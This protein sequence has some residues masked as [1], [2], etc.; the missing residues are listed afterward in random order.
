MT[1]VR[2]HQGPTA[3]GA[4][5]ALGARAYAVGAEVAFADGAADL[6]TAAHEAA[7]VV[8]QRRGVARKGLDGGAS[9][10]FE[11][12]AD[13]VADAVVRGAPAAPILDRMA[14]AGGGAPTV[15]RD[16][17]PNPGAP[18]ADAAALHTS[19]GDPVV[20]VGGPASPSIYMSADWLRANGV[21]EGAVMVTG[22]THPAVVR[23]IIEKL[24]P[25]YPWA[26]NRPSAQLDDISA[27]FLQ[28][29][30]SGWT[31]GE[32]LARLD[33]TIFLSMGLPPERP[34]QVFS[35]PTG[36][37]LWIDTYYAFPGGAAPSPESGELERARLAGS[38][39]A[40]LEAAIGAPML[41]SERVQATALCEG[42]IRGGGGVEVVPWSSDQLVPFFGAEAVRAYVEARETPDGSATSVIEVP[43]G[44]FSLPSDATPDEAAL[45][46]RM[47]SEIYGSAE[48]REGRDTSATALLRQDIAALDELDRSPDRGELIAI[49]REMGQ[50]EG[51]MAQRIAIARAQLRRRQGAR[52][53]GESDPAMAG[54]AAP[55]PVARPVEG[56]ILNKSGEINAGMKAH[57]G[58]QVD[59]REVVPA[60]AHVD[61]VWHAAPKL[62]G[63]DDAS[64]P[65][66]R[67]HTSYV[68]TGSDGAFNDKLFEVKL[69]RPGI[70]T[71]HADVE[72]SFYHP[73]HFTQDVEVL[74]EGDRLKRMEDGATDSWGKETS[75][76]P[77]D[78][79]SSDPA[80]IVPPML[81]PLA[82]PFLPLLSPGRP[83]S[84]DARGSRAEGTLHSAAPDATAT[85]ER[86]RLDQVID[87]L[88]EIEKTYTGSD[89]QRTNIR[90]YAADRRARLEKARDQIGA[91]AG[92]ADNHMVQVQGLYASRTHGVKS[93]PLNLVAW[94]RTDGKTFHGEL[95]DNTELYEPE[96]HHFTAQAS[97]HEAL[98]EALFVDLSKSYP[99]GSISFAYQAHDGAAPT[100]DFVRFTRPTDSVWS[101][102]KAV[103]FSSEASA[104]VNV[105]SLLLTIFPPTAPVGVG[106]SLVYNGAELAAQVED[107]SRKGTMR[108]SRLVD[109]GL[110]A[111]DLIPVAGKASRALTVG[112][113]TY[114]VIEAAQLAGDAYL[115]AEEGVHQVDNLRGGLV[116][117]LA[118]LQAVIEDRRAVNASDPELVEMTARAKE[119]E[120]Q[121]RQAA[122]SVFGGLVGQRAIQMASMAAI[123]RVAEPHLSEPGKREGAGGDGEPPDPHGKRADPREGGDDGSVGGTRGAEV[124]A[125]REDKTISPS[126]LDKEVPKATPRGAT[127]VAST[128][129][130][131]TTRV[132]RVELGAGKHVDVQ[133][134]L[135]LG[136]VVGE[137]GAHGEESGAGR[138]S[139]TRP[140]EGQPWRAVVTL[141]RRLQV[142]DVK[143]VAGHELNEA[144]EIV[145]RVEANPTFDVASEHQASLMKRGAAPG[146]SVSAH[147]VASVLELDALYEKAAPALRNYKAAKDGFQKHGG[148]APIP[149]TVLADYEKHGPRLARMLDVM[150]FADGAQLDARLMLID[151]HCGKNAPGLKQH[152]IELHQNKFAEAEMA[153]FTA[154][155]LPRIPGAHLDPNLKTVVSPEFIRHLNFVKAIRDD[156]WIHWGVSGGHTV[157]ALQAC[158]AGSPRVLFFPTGKTAAG[159]TSYREFAQ[160]LWKGAGAPPAAGDPRRPTSLAQVNPAE[161]EQAGVPKT[162]ADDVM[163][164]VVDVEAT[165]REQLAPPRDVTNQKIQMLNV[166][167]QGSG[168]PMDIIV[169]HTPPD[170]YEVETAYVKF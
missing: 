129:A 138:V 71:V 86:E 160:F 140:A 156:D 135:R 170:A 49:L 134:E 59:Y 150:G 15:Q 48:R 114:R 151:R 143:F 47:L 164:M 111:L 146:A 68:D 166:P 163:Q 34:V 145:R 107:E 37:E 64:E 91:A 90:Q 157:Q 92:D 123:R 33:R 118:E 93:G 4:A 53:V 97:T 5:R 101:D 18:P 76:S 78:F 88:H 58:F 161:W 63:G 80:V 113:R 23:A 84:S 36:V 1:G 65:V 95:F 11:V 104:V 17:D 148:K 75:R 7:H 54:D 61:I 155:E 30:P 43:G 24:R 153:R 72:H 46:Q 89:P 102:V 31:Q 99:S 149:A 154:T 127:F 162:V 50:G 139:V 67:E 133:V 55:P 98:M 69:A 2:A 66:D 41:A 126:N 45:V 122:A 94:F 20:V 109:V 144:A 152:A 52:A 147:D 13:E 119:L 110:L 16:A 29:P 74:A 100:G 21:T 73:N 142:G 35:S 79:E 42:D 167:M 130:G 158:A 131:Q 60:A 9:D 87:K 136:M 19:P 28:M 32:L 103:A 77:H 14:G 8:Q 25:L 82:I 106:L 6:H 85:R 3:A 10:P 116:T 27:V 40:A 57:F 81:G 125:L 120:T 38:A 39:V 56:H 96:Q 115:L 117:E 124:Y 121:I 51:G 44:G 165:V 168:L 105:A 108:A 26:A 132:L 141:D 137:G 83:P 112:Q 12:H 159:R 128:E 70:Y 62:G 22:A 169:R